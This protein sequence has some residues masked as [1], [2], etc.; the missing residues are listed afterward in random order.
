[1]EHP[2]LSAGTR[3]APRP[4][5]LLPADRSE[6]PEPARTAFHDVLRQL[7]RWCKRHDWPTATNAWVAEEAVRQSW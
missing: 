3:E 7:D 4:A 5:T 6:W 2:A 1:M